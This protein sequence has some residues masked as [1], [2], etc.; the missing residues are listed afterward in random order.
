M[1]GA[2]CSLPIPSPAPAV[3]VPGGINM[4]VYPGSTTCTGTGVSQS[5]NNDIPV[6]T[7]VSIGSGS[8][9]R[10]SCVK[11]AYSAPSSAVIISGYSGSTCP[12]TGTA[13]S[14]FALTTNTCLSLYG[15]NIKI[16]C[17]SASAGTVNQYAGPGC[18]GATTS[19]SA[20]SLGFPFGC[21]VTTGSYPTVQTV[22]CTAPFGTA[23]GAR[24]GADVAAAAGAAMGAALL[25]LAARA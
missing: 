6:G 18:T 1:L 5:L 13:L 21:S 25:A 15:Q 3:C 14:A 19:L 23:S 4:T 20:A 17:S 10:Y 12:A 16:T 8:Y 2:A 22:A 24:A 7:C 9:V 11:G